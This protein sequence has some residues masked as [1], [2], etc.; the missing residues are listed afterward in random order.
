MSFQNPNNFE[1]RDDSDAIWLINAIYYIPDYSDV[2]KC[3]RFLHRTRLIN[4]ENN[5]NL[6]DKT[7][8][9]LRQ[10]LKNLKGLTN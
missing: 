7:S 1:V 5:E 2:T 10:I 6:A 3:D 8:F 4:F 9:R